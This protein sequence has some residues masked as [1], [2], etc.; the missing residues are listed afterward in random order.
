VT[1]GPDGGN[2][3]P[4][5]LTV[6]RWTRRAVAT[7]VPRPILYYVTSPDAEAGDAGGAVPLAAALDVRPWLDRSAAVAHCG[8]AASA[9]GRGGRECFTS[10]PPATTLQWDLLPPGTQVDRPLAEA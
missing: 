9:A 10:D 6:H 1:F 4:D 7:C 8:I 5:H 3:H 2:G